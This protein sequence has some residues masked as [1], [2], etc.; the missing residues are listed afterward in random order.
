MNVGEAYQVRFRAVRTPPGWLADWQSQAVEFPAFA[1]LGATRDEGAV[2]VEARDDL[3]VRPERVEQLTPLDGRRKADRSRPGRRQPP[4]WPIATKAPST[5]PRWWSERTRPRL[6]ARTFS[7]FRVDP[8]ALNCHYELNFTV[9][10]ARVRRLSFWLPKDT[11]ASLG[12]AALDGVKL[13]ESDPEMSSGR[14]RWNVSLAEPQR[15][16]VRLAVDFQQPLPGTG[17]FSAETQLPADVGRKHGPVPCSLPMVTADGVAYQSGLVAVEGCAELDVRV[18]TSARPVDV[19]ELADAEYQPGRRLLGAYGFVGDPAAV[20]LD[21]LRHPGYAIC[22]AIVQRCELDTNLSPDG[23]SQTQ[24][25][26]KLR[27]KAVYLQVKLPAR[28]PN[29]GRPN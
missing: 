23:Q 7:F 11:P 6:T 16:R 24:A 14:R 21:V 8:D 27:T 13:K 26:F 9:E 1:V 20:K 3:T 22:P 25:R 29:C 18:D 10:E 12:I 4:R 28:A 19:G 5:R 17:P 15:E 2:A